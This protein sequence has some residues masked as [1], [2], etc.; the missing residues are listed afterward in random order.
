MSRARQLHCWNWLSAKWKSTW[1]LA[2]HVSIT[3]SLKDKTKGKTKS[4]LWLNIPY[5]RS[6]SSD[7]QTP[8]S[9]W[10]NEAIAEFFNQLRGVWISNETRLLS[11][12]YYISN[13]SLFKEKI[14]FKVVEILCSLRSYIQTTSWY[15][16]P[17]CFAH[18]LLRLWDI[19]IVVSTTSSIT[20]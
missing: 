9:E 13:E 1:C 2:P 12:W 8:R 3:I 19:R 7:I 5:T 11:V 17:L 10:K 15:W 14:G 6:V 20:S 4:S 18:E 16:F